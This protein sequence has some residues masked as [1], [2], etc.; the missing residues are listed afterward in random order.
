MS[1]WRS[2]L[3]NFQVP[4]MLPGRQT[5]ARKPR[6]ANNRRPKKVPPRSGSPR[7]NQTFYMSL[8]PF[9]VVRGPLIDIGSMPLTKTLP[10]TPFVI[11]R[12][13]QNA[14]NVVAV[15]DGVTHTFERDFSGYFVPHRI[16]DGTTPAASTLPLYVFFSFPPDAMEVINHVVKFFVDR[17][18]VIDNVDEFV[19]L[20]LPMHQLSITVNLRCAFSGDKMRK[21]F[22]MPCCHRHVDCY[23]LC[24]TWFDDLSPPKCPFCAR[25]IDMSR[26]VYNNWLK[27]VLFEAPFRSNAV[28]ITTTRDLEYTV[29]E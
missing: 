11:P 21:P 4:L 5:Q 14:N 28:V 6:A 1:P 29:I 15:I 19:E 24:K 10:G 9:F 16:T 7:Q 27:R 23:N 2:S 3:W 13:D 17:Q 18:M 22:L 8:H 12:D 26:L 25:V 20:L